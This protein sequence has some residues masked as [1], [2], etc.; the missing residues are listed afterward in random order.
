M[1]KKKEKKSALASTQQVQNWKEVESEARETVHLMKSIH[2]LPSCDEEFWNNVKHVSTTGVE[3]ERM[4]RK[5]REKR[6]I[7]LMRGI[8]QTTMR[9][10]TTIT[11][12]VI[13]CPVP[14]TLI[15]IRSDQTRK[16]VYLLRDIC[17]SRLISSGTT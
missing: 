13:N 9:Q 5:A 7:S 10:E 4:G 11:H 17:Q 1:W 15:L 2:Y 16:K 12:L 3:L 6:R 8:R 14:R